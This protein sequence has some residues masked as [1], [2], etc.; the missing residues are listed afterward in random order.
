MAQIADR[1]ST[2]YRVELNQSMNELPLRYL[3]CIYACGG[4]IVLHFLLHVFGYGHQPGLQRNPLK[5]PNTLF[6]GISAAY[7]VIVALL[8]FGAVGLISTLRG[9]DEPAAL[10]SAASAALV[11]L[12]AGLTV[13]GFLRHLA[14]HANAGHIH[15]LVGLRGIVS[16]DIPAEQQGRGSVRLV[17]HMR[18]AEY[19]AVTAGGA[20]PVGASIRVAA[21][22]GLDAV[23]V[24]P[25]VDLEKVW[26]TFTSGN[27]PPETDAEP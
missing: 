7:A 1:I 27:T 23:A 16:A 19:P 13:Q 6:D 14:R 18:P 20:L 3:A 10:L 11:T 25:D 15:T 8:V 12:A 24:L 9:R 5:G 22:A 2:A 26:R 4:L 21:V 17:V